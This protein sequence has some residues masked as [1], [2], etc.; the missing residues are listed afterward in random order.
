MVLSAACPVR[1]PCG[2][3]CWVYLSR[4]DGRTWVGWLETGRRVLPNGRRLR[5][6]VPVTAASLGEVLGRAEA[7]ARRQA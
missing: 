3:V 7:R 1:L 4:L 5:L 2:A 6:L